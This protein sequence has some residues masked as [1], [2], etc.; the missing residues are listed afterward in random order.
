MKTETIFKKAVIDMKV[1]A[2]KDN[3]GH[4]RVIQPYGIFKSSHGIKLFCCYQLS[5][6]SESGKI[7]NWR[8]IPVREV[9]SIQIM[10]I[11]FTTRNDYTPDNNIIYPHWLFRNNNETKSFSK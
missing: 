1:C 10:S 2:L 5:G 4:Q 6:Y 3:K 11:S 9:E 8:N 7:P